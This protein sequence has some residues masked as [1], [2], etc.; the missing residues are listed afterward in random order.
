MFHLTV[1]YTWLYCESKIINTSQIQGL[2]PMS[3]WRCWSHL[4]CVEC[5]VST[6][7]E[8]DKCAVLESSSLALMVFCQALLTR[9]TVHA[10]SPLACRTSPWPA[11][12]G[13]R[14][15]ALRC[16]LWIS[17]SHRW[18]CDYSGG[19]TNWER[20]WRKDMEK[21]KNFEEKNNAWFRDSLLELIWAE[22]QK[23]S[24]LPSILPVA[25]LKKI[26]FQKGFHREPKL[27][28]VCVCVCV[29]VRE[30]TIITIFSTL[31]KILCS[32]KYPRMLKVHRGTI[33][34]NKAFIFK[35]SFLAKRVY[36]ILVHRYGWA[37]HRKRF[38]H[39]V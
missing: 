33:K 22:H 18:P 30:K 13:N 16:G 11:E 32:G 5:I 34:A 28:C 17:P 10:W 39:L 1:C 37:L 25:T 15:T 20:V 7:A 4:C 14:H 23:T 9:H 21:K 12:T 2:D 36:D 29:C 26:R 24:R 35:C 19:A 6:A 27:L 38:F 8:H 31:N 3:Q